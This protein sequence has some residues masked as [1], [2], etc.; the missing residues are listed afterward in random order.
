[1]PLA[2]LQTRTFYR[3]ASAQ[4]EIAAMTGSPAQTS[5]L[6][7]ARHAVLQI[8]PPD[9]NAMTAQEIW[10]AI[11]A[12]VGVETAP[13]AENTFSHFLPCTLSQGIAAQYSRNGYFQFNLECVLYQGSIQGAQNYVADR[14]NLPNYA[15]PMFQGNPHDQ[16]WLA[17]SGSLITTV[18]HVTPQG[19]SESMYSLD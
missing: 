18:T 17:Y 12:R 10:A 3:G 4:W 14:A 9:L 5:V 7:S 1:M 11:V 8:Q 13:G 16:E 19:A 6:C 15:V 2:P